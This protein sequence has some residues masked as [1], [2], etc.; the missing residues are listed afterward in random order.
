VHI[1]LT[2][3]QFFTLKRLLKLAEAAEDY[4]VTYLNAN[5]KE[6]PTRYSSI[7]WNQGNKVILEIPEEE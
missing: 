1:E 7:L 4:P 3:D 2:V 6:T 5:I